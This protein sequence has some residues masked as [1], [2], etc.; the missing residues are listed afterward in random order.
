MEIAGDR[1]QNTAC[2]LL[3]IAYCLQLT[4]YRF[5]LNPSKS[6]A[7]FIVFF[8]FIVLLMAVGIE[9]ST[10]FRFINPMNPINSINSM[11]PIPLGP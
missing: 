7:L 8:G 11:S 1:M 5:P 10:R 2:F 3:L 6:V 4:A 9:T